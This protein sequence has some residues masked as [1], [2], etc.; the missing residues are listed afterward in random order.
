MRSAKCLQR[1]ALNGNSATEKTEKPS[2][3]SAGRGYARGP[4]KEDLELRCL[5]KY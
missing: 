3:A 1:G 2:F 5:V 4:W